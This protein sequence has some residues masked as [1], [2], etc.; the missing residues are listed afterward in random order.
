MRRNWTPRR[1]AV[2][3]A[4][5]LVLTVTGCGEATEEG[6][7]AAAPA[8]TCQAGTVS[9]GETDPE[10]EASE[11]D[12]EALVVYSGRNEELVAPV[13]EQFT[14][15]TGIE[16]SVRYGSTSSI[17]AQLLEEGA[18]SPADVVL[19]QDAGA[20]GA[21]ADANCL[22]E[23]PDATVEQTFE[24]YAD[25]D[26]RWVPLTGRARVVIYDPQS[27]AEADL[28]ADTAA[29]VDP[30]YSGKIAIAPGNAGFQAFITAIRVLQDSAAAEEFLQGLVDNAAPVYD[31]N[32]AILDAVEAGEVPMGLVNHYYWFEQAAEVGAENMR[33][34]LYYLRDG[35]A[36]SLV[37]VTGSG[38][39]SS[40]D[41]S[42]D[43]LALVDF[44][45]GTDA[46]EYFA[47]E[48]YEY[49]MIASVPVADELP[50][51]SD[52]DA[53]TIDLDD[54][55]SLSATLQLITASGLA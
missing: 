41:R 15:A 17:T 47:Q 44:L 45:L 12:D 3:A 22:A 6:D 2:L 55:A 42:T 38:V 18:D 28:P 46:Q 53:P 52:L 4:G 33:S 24:E 43:A 23:L 39:V 16:V 34:Q 29:L 9:Y 1:T 37:N 31:G 5:A 51:L 19:L 13:L 36:G 21:L 14:A 20:L 40:T 35:A 8:S 7:T 30:A 48:T 54:L 26:R 10:V 25:D 11:V 27:I 32:S 49:P 50:P